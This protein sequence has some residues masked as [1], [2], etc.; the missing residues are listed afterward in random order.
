M[1]LCH[2]D[3]RRDSAVHPTN[4]L[5]ERLGMFRF[6]RATI[7]GLRTSW[8][9]LAA[10]MVVLAVMAA[11]VHTMTN[12]A[13]ALAEQHRLTREAEAAAERAVV[14]N[15]AASDSLPIPALIGGIVV[16]F[17]VG[18][19][20]G[21]VERRRRASRRQAALLRPDPV[22]D[23][24]L[25]ARAARVAPAPQPPAPKPRKPPRIVKPAPPPPAP[26]PPPPEPKRSEPVAEPPEPP[27]PPE[28]KR[29]EPVAEPPEPKRPE[30]VA[31]PPEPKRL[32]PV[33]EP[34]EPAEP[35][36][37]PARVRPAVPPPPR[38][39][40]RPRPRAAD[41]ALGGAPEVPR[42]EDARPA[43]REPKVS[44]DAPEAVGRPPRRRP[45]AP[46]PPTPVEAENLPA[47]R[48]ARDRPWPE[49]AETLWTCEIAWKAGYVKS[50]FRAMA[51]PPGG[52]GRRKPI[53][54]SPSL[55]WTLM[56]DPEPPT[57]EMVAGV[58]ALIGALVTAGWE[59]TEPGGPWY[60]QRFLWRGEG[61]PGP[62]EVPKPAQ[63]A[64]PPTR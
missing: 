33:A 51:G 38:P 59:R 64:E 45:V 13:P 2:K 28:P 42:R 21:Q 22:P 63:P 26:P 62:V 6:L 10:F 56:T 31:E 34:P 36:A 55:R 60:A 29:P 35:V 19:T 8:W 54:E 18:L 11:G 57:A 37:P 47:R 27:K 12:A 17:A 3:E 61:E 30:P 44:L 46:A 20:A 49:E 9:Y 24:V 52:D 41:S 25:P 15:P 50:T 4:E 53:G 7:D 32:E 43:R 23:P 16:A 5:E 14:P 48:F 39:A 58:K 1:A 40:A